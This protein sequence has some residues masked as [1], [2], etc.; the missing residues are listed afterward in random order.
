MFRKL[1]LKF[2]MIA[3]GSVFSVIFL[4]VCAINIA[5][6]IRMTQE[7]DNLVQTLVEGNG[8]FL[9]RPPFGQNPELPFRTRYFTVEFNAQGEIIFVNTEKIAAVQQ[10]QAISY[11]TE[12]YRKEKTSGYYGNYRFAAG[13][14]LFGGTR[15]VFVDCSQ[16]LSSF[17]N[18][19][20]ISIG[21]ASGGLLLIFCLIFLLSGKIMK[22]VAESYEKQKRF[23][24][25]AS[26]DIKTPLTIIGADAD[27]L[28]M[29]NG[30]NEWTE[31]IKH[32]VARLTSL[33]EKLIL[34]AKMDEGGQAPKMTDFSL[35][36]AVEET[37][38]SFS[39]IAL[40]QGNQFTLKIQP[41]LSYCGNEDLIRRLVGI[42]VENALK[43]SD[44]GGDISVSL[45]E[46]AGKRQ[47]VVKNQSKEFSEK[48]P[49]RL[50]DRF[51]RGDA[52][53]NSEKAGHGIGLSLARSIVTA[54]RGKITVKK[55][56]DTVLFIA[57]L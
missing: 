1:R 9:G 54:H 21:V 4:I 17:F 39:S 48:N 56:G 23:I 42:L 20:W 41:N 14:M 37:A 53:R 29:Q 46:N 7:A 18:V 16:E 49:E 38:N 55:D 2:I 47:L 11:A 44:E 57:T 22:P 30:K 24:T 27:V 50:F 28:E 45:T 40:A 43:Y 10:E 13:Q 51:Y 36:D 19:L 26:H 3:M 15:Y 12:L 52:S 6:R 8:E 32:E 34:L 35:S 31:D 25:D 33:T 5:N